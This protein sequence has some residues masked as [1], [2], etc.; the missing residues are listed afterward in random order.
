MR[1][2]EVT[3]GLWIG[4]MTAIPYRPT[5]DAVLTVNE[6]AGHVDE[7]IVH[8][9]IH[10]EDGG[11]P[12][13]TQLD[14]AV[15]WAHKQWEQGRTLL[16]RSEHGINRPAY[17]AAGMFLAMGADGDEAIASVLR[18]V[19]GGLTNPAFKLHLVGAL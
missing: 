8:R 12:Q 13:T 2:N 7:D 1:E 3:S 15:K 6:T 4:D 10:M 14:A 9:H 19:P 17:V 16:I 11:D 18:R 5:Y